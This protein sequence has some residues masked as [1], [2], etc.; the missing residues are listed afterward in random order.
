MQG[1]DTKQACSHA[2]RWTLPPRCNGS[3]LVTH[4]LRHPW[5]TPRRPIVSNMNGI[6][7]REENLRL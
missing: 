4:Q 1:I 2:M 5:S 3:D 6:S 7:E